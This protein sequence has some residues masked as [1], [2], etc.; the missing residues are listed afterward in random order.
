MSGSNDNQERIE[1]LGMSLVQSVSKAGVSDIAAE[2]AEIA[3]DSI[4]DEGLLEE[5]PVLGW[6][7]KTYNVL[8]TIRDRI[9]LKKVASFLSGTRNISEEEKH[10]FLES[11]EGDPENFKKVGESIVLLLERQ[12]DFEKSLILGKVFARYVRGKID[13]EQFL[14]LAKSIELAFIG[15]LR[16]LAKHYASIKTYSPNSGKPFSDWLDYQTS[17]SLYSSGLIRCEGYTEDIYQPNDVGEELLRC[18]EE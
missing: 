8:G 14:K 17:Q 2:A 11:T 3:L 9:F 4:L 16:S 1:N 5:V 15:D 13:Y 12:E 6:L 7:K 10:R 18:L